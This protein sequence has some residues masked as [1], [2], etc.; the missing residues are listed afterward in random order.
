MGSGK[1]V[2]DV[3]VVGEKRCEMSSVGKIGRMPCGEVVGGP[4]HSLELRKR[5]AI[6]DSLWLEEDSEERFNLIERILRSVDLT[7]VQFAELVLDVGQERGEYPTRYRR[8]EQVQARR[9]A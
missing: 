3:R 9:K 8:I 4:W 2:V 5:M 1:E 6:I 7:Y